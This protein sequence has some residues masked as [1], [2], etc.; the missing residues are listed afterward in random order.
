MSEKSSTPFAKHPFVPRGK[1]LN[2]SEIEGEKHSLWRS[3]ASMPFSI[4]ITA[5]PLETIPC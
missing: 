3:N 1:R 4:S 5:E 2:T